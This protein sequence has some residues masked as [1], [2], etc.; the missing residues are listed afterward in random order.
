MTELQLITGNKNFSPSSLRSWLLLQEF[1][2]Q[3]TEIAID[4]FKGDSAEKILSLIHI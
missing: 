2:V 3:F 1:N 4:L